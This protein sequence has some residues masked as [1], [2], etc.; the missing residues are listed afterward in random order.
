MNT[1]SVLNNPTQTPAISESF[2]T[3]TH[4]SRN[5][6]DLIGRFTQQ[7]DQENPDQIIDLKDLR[8]NPEGNI[9]VPQN[10]E[11]ALTPW[12]QKQLATLVGIKWDK[13]FERAN[14]EEQAEEINRRFTRY[15]QSIKLRTSRIT[16]NNAN[17]ILKAFVSPKYTPVKDSA[18]AR[19]MMESLRSF[20]SEF[21][22]IRY[23]ITDRTI[24]YVIGIG[25]TYQVGGPGEVGDI[26]GGILVRN[27]GCGFASLTIALHLTRLIC[28]NG[29]T[30][31][32]PGSNL[33]HHRHTSGIT[34]PKT[35][36]FLEDK[37]RD[38]PTKLRQSGNIMLRAN[39]TP[40][41]NV[42]EMIQKILGDSNLP[43]RM[44][45]LILQAFAYEPRNNAFGVSSAITRAAQQFDPEDRLQLE[46]AASTYIQSM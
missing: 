25:H 15:D 42:E 7:E 34:D 45:E 38:V 36:A 41:S 13:W 33:L 3:F 29:M 19:I 35:F 4:G 16:G 46:E 39:Q 24:S 6:F 14:P 5:I 9:V 10:R 40:V 37:F 20:E 28:R 8:M 30:A 32:L 2:N 21:R 18:I 43:K 31:P 11:Y 1:Q 22:I 26:W 17:G 23:D 12:S 44:M 27:S